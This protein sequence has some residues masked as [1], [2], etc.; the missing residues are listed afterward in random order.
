MKQHVSP[1]HGADLVRFARE[2]VDLL[3]AHPTGLDQRGFL[4]EYFSGNPPVSREDRD[5]YWAEVKRAARYSTAMFDLG[6]EGWSFIR[7]L[8]GP[9]RGQ[10]YYLAVATIVSGQPTV[11]VPYPLAEQL[12]ERATTE[13]STRTR[14]RMR[15]RV[16]DLQSKTASG[17]PKL[18]AEAE[19]KFDEILLISTRL[20]AINFDSGM[21]IEDL[22]QLANPRDR[23]LQI[24]SRPIQRA[25]DAVE[26]AQ[27]QINELAGLVHG[28]QQIMTGERRRLGQGA[29]A[30]DR[31]EQE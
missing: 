29:G 21:S 11:E 9:R 8:Q 15:I 24:L 16:A 22:R 6:E 2:V 1:R 31:F 26:K 23:R 18:M 19:K 12:D 3:R 4:H 25:L 7:A 5:F 28:L 17:N 14:S 13:W 10:F 27:K 30:I 20:A